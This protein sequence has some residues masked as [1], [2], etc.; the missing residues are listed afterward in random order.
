MTTHAK[1]E[2]LLGKTC[3]SVKGA[4]GGYCLLFK[5]SDGSAYS[6]I[7]QQDCCEI[8]TI[9]DITGD[10]SDLVGTPL[11]KAEEASQSNTNPDGTVSTCPDDSFTWT[12]YKFA[13]IKGYVD[14]RWY[15]ASNGYYSESVS[16]ICTTLPQN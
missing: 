12:F 6:F 4:V 16:L 15:G 7:H 2:D 8:V 14:V 1:I 11:L 10:L 3:T 13:T 5:F 9:E